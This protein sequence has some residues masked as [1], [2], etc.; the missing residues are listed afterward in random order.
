LFFSILARQLIRRGSFAS[1]DDLVIKIN[2]L[3]ANCNRRAKPSPR[4]TTDDLS[5]WHK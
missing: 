2:T 5:K 4:P 1:V 3:I